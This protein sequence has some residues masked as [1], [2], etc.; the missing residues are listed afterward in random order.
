ML[1]LQ[2]GLKSCTFLAKNKR[3]E[4]RGEATRAKGGG[5]QAEEEQVS[6]KFRGGLGGRFSFWVKVFVSHVPCTGD[7]EFG[8]D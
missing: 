6:G 8:G 4:S 2:P 1:D 7:L 3:E 5:T